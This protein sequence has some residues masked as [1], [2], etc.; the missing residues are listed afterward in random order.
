MRSSID[1][2]VRAIGRGEVVIVTDD[3]SRENEGDL[4]MAAEK[5]TPEA[6]NFMAKFARGLIC[7][8]LTEERLEQLAGFREQ[9][10]ILRLVMVERVRIG[11]EDGRPPHDGELGDGGRE[12]TTMSPGFGSVTATP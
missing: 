2:A 11:H 4:C 10:R 8:S 6:I 5:V 1:A 7:L 12:K 3:E 9:A